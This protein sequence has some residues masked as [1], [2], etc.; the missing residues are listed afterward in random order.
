M[1]STSTEN[2]PESLRIFSSTGVVLC[3][4]WLFAPDRMRTFNGAAKL[5]FASSSGCDDKC[6]CNPVDHGLTIVDLL[7]MVFQN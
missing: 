4:S 1:V 7:S 3:Q 2:R 5:A 6:L